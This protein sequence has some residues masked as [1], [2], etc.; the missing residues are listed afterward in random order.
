MA[1]SRA[2]NFED[3]ANLDEQI[4]VLLTCKPLPESQ[5]KILCDKVSLSFLLAFLCFSAA[6]FWQNSN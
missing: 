1:E 5:I 2:I 6:S 4:K 3:I